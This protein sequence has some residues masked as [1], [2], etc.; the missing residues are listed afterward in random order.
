MFKDEGDRTVARSLKVRRH[1]L[2]EWS[3]QRHTHEQAKPCPEIFGATRVVR[4]RY[5]PRMLTVCNVTLAHA[6]PAAK[7]QRALVVC[8]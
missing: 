7:W 8:V 5:F 3:W 4:R 6:K 2:K 1:V